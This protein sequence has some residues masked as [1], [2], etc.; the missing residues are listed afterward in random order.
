M[1][2]NQCR[3]LWNK[4]ITRIKSSLIHHYNIAAYMIYKRLNKSILHV[5]IIKFIFHLKLFKW[6]TLM[7]IN[8]IFESIGLGIHQ[9]SHL[10]G[11]MRVS[12][13]ACTQQ[14]VLRC[15]CAT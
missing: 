10:K 12:Q 11:N 5:L 2:L 9:K 1:K 7:D 8:I 14:G 13:D 6:D 3:N 4:I 15:D